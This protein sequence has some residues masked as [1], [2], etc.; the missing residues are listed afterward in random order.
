VLKLDEKRYALR[1]DAIGSRFALEQI[2]GLGTVRLKLAT[3]AA[4][5]EIADL[6]LMLMS[7]DG[8]ACSLRGAD[9]AVQ[10]PVGRYALSALSLSLSRKADREPWNFVF[11]RLLGPDERHWYDV[12]RDA[13]VIID[14]IGTPRFVLEFPNGAENVKPGK[15]LSIEPRLYTQDGL[16]INSCAIGQHGRAAVY[17]SGPHADV[18]FLS[19]AGKLLWSHQSGFA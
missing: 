17:G 7:E 8:S 19:G 5:V 9:A 16:L 15:S 18:E 13:E 14:P 1:S 10:V 2:N 12:A 4:G 3:L 6:E 11:S